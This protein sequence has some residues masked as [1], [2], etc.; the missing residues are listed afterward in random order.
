MYPVQYPSPEG[1]RRRVGRAMTPRT[2]YWI[3]CPDYETGPYRTETIAR[4]RLAKIEEAGL[5][6]LP[7]LVVEREHP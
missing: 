4:R 1:P 5:C 6:A 7:H 2:T 3:V